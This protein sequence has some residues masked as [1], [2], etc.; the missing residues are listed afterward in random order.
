MQSD[1]LAASILCSTDGVPSPMQSLRLGQGTS[2]Q[3]SGL[4]RYSSY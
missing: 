4:V 1:A 3:S 2:W